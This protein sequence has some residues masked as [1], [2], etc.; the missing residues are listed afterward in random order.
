[1]APALVAQMCA[2]NHSWQ[3]GVA[4]LG[5]REGSE[6]QHRALQ[7]GE[8]GDQGYELENLKSLS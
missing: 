3:K 6:G 4:L 1:M 2:L 7:A 8:P 5:G